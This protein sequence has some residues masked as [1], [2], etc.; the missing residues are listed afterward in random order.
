V[1][2]LFPSD[3]I[4]FDVNNF[5]TIEIKFEDKFDVLAEL[6]TIRSAI[7]QYARQAMA[8]GISVDNPILTYCP[9]YRFM[10]VDGKVAK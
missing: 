5:K 9:D 4:P 8:T 3:K 2:P 1:S 7:A 10:R 6:E